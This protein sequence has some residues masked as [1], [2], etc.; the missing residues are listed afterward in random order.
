MNTMAEFD[1]IRKIHRKIKVRSND[2][3]IG[4]GDDCA[5]ID[6]GKKLLV[7]VDSQVENIHFRRDWGRPEY[8]GRKLV[9]VNMSDIFAKGG[10]PKYALLSVGLSDKK[11]S[12]FIPGY[13][14]GVISEL[15]I[16]KIQLIGG[17]VSSVKSDLFFDLVMIGQVDGKNLRLRKGAGAGDIIAVSGTLGNASAG[18]EILSK[19]RAPAG[20]YRGLTDA[21]FSPDIVYYGNRKFWDYVTS[22]IDISDGLTGDLGHILESSGCGA[23]IDSDSIPVSEELRH[24]CRENGKDIFHF[25]LSGGEDYRLLVTLR[26]NIPKK[27]IKENGFFV[28]GKIVRKKGLRIRGLKKRYNSFEHF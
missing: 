12:S 24:Y 5:L 11:Q 13:I 8:L 15:N 6:N 17:N 7:T 1:F 3:I 21:F 16:N 23:E 14:D 27:L 20:R 25:A 22:S 28:I 19:D 2:V 26:K 4:I 9:R 18:V 10:I